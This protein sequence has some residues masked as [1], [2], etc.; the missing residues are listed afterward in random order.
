MKLLCAGPTSLSPSVESAMQGIVT[1]PDLDPEYEVFHREVEKKLSRVVKTERPT[2]ILLGEG[3]IA[4]ESAICSLVEKG[5][6][7]LVLTNGVFGAGF[8]DYVRYMGATPVVYESDPRRGFDLDA[9][10]A[11]LEKDSDFAVATMVHC[12]TPSGITNDM[13]GICRLLKSYGI[14]SVVDCVSSFGGEAIDFDE[15]GV[16]LMLSATQKCLSAPTGLSMVTISEAAEEKM[17]RRAEIPSYYMNLLN[18]LSG[19]EDFAFPYTMSEHLTYALDRALDEW[20]MR[21]ALDLHRRYGE[22][23]REIFEAEGFELYPKDSFSDTVTAVVVPEE[24]TATDILNRARNKGVMISKGAG[25]LHDRII[26]IGH[27]GSNISEENFRAL[28]CVLDEVFSELGRSTH[29]AE[30][31]EGKISAIHR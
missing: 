13:R 27:M 29:F 3:M 12:E 5:E 25:A 15:D 1:N 7:V 18:Y 21:D 23:T 24:M 22:M 6:R 4:L 17:R 9:L 30:D 10:K 2:V 31:F 28:F 16:D 8:A 14:L 11:Y 20:K 26:R 19:A